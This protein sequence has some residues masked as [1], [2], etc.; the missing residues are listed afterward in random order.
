MSAD[1]VDL[2]E[3]RLKRERRHAR[4]ALR[5]AHFDSM[6]PVEQQAFLDSVRRRQE[7]ARRMLDHLQKVKD[8][9]K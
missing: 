5:K 2:K 8:D 1:V 6:P 7:H 3:F 4:I 9:M